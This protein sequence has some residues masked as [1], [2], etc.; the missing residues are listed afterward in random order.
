M[1]YV[2][3]KYCELQDHEIFAMSGVWSGHTFKH[4]VAAAASVMPLYAL[5]RRRQHANV[6]LR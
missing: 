4:L 3:A 1:L 2:V 5:I 6:S